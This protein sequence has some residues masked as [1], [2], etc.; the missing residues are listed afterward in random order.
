MIIRKKILQTMLKTVVLS[1]VAAQSSFGAGFSLYG[2]S[3]PYAM[4][5]FAAGSAA[6][7]YDASTGWYNPAGLALIRNQQLVAGA[8]GIFPDVD[9]SGTTHFSTITIPDYVQAFRNT[10]AALN[11]GV[12]SLHYAKP[13]GERATFG[14]SVVAPFG[15]AT[16]WARTHPARYAAT[17]SELITSNFSPE[18]GGQLTEHLA[19]GGGIDLQYARVKFNSVLGAPA[20]LQEVNAQLPF[21]TNITPQSLDSYSYNKGNSFNVGFHAGALLMFNENHTR[22][23]V[24]YQSKM[25]HK[26]HGYSRLTGLLA[27]PTLDPMDPESILISNPAAFKSN[28]LTSNFIEFPDLVTLSVYQDVT[29]RTALMASA[30]YTNWDVFKTIE[31]DNVAAYVSGIGQS[32]VNSSS[33]QNYQNTWRFA[34]GANYKANPNWLI[35]AGIGYDET[36]TVYPYRSVRLPDQDRVALS[37]GTHYQAWPSVGI[38]VG[39]TY[40][41]ILKSA[42]INETIEIGETSSFNVLA[43]GEGHANLVGAQITWYIDQVPE[44]VVMTK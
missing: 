23:G 7:A 32:L 38:D 12:P 41:K 33:L 6:E 39:Y 19:L 16:E 25:R 18:L 5:N 43:K 4:G 28:Q 24:N 10:D 27:N 40:L 3:G 20:F 37:I 26:F 9:V 36:P 42:Y 31:L 17:F 11:A 13:L 44:K 14:F 21:L 8:V 2:E 29:D 34:L 15:L 1:T 35:R 30:V 22:L